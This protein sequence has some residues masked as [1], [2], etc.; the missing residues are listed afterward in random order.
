M[1]IAIV[2]DR[3]KRLQQFQSFDI[4]NEPSIVVITGQSFQDLVDNLEANNLTVLYNYDVVAV[5]RSAMSEKIRDAIKNYCAKTRKPLVFFSGGIT[6]SYYKE[7]GFSFLLMNSK[8]FYS[9]HLKIFIDHVNESGKP[10][11][12]MLQFG[13]NWKISMLLS[14]RNRIAVSLSKEELKATG[15]RDIG[16][17]GLIRWIGNLELS[18]SII[19]DLETE[20]TK[21]ILKRKADAS[22]SLAE[23]EQI[24]NAIEQQLRMML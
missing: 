22:V 21:V 5:H 6:S 19:S 17:S 18:E 2:E 24:K 4:W 13:A 20:T 7:T 8:E 12:L 14:L 10:N 16:I 1:K 11:L 23:L 15:V 9:D 3:A